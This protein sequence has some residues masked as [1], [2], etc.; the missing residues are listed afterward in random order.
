MQKK[1]NHSQREEKSLNWKIKGILLFL[2]I[3]KCK[4]EDA[5]ILESANV[6]KKGKF[7][8]AIF[9]LFGHWAFCAIKHS[10]FYGKMHK[11]SCNKECLW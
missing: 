10:F 9:H 11:N 4:N 8:A 6:K 5:M 2:N 3:Y 1:K 7:I